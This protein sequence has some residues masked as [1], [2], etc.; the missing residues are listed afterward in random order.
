MKNYI[1]VTVASLLIS[2]MVHASP[3]SI[4]VKNESGSNIYVTLSFKSTQQ[5]TISGQATTVCGGA[6][7]ADGFVAKDAT[8]I[9]S[10]DSCGR[11]VSVKAFATKASNLRVASRDTGSNTKI[12]NKI[13]V[14][15]GST[16]TVTKNSIK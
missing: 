11:L 6:G 5:G 7:I 9:I 15:H 16:I 12:G 8:G 14:E 1:M 10:Y 13:S 2:G 3:R 4:T